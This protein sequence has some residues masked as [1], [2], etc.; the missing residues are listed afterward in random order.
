MNVIK[1]LEE[2]YISN[3]EGDWEH[4]WNVKI[5]SIDMLGWL[6]S[7]NLVDTGVDGKAFPVYKVERSVDDWVH[8]KVENSI[9]NGSGGTGNLEEILIVFITWL[10]KVDSNFKK[11]K[12]LNTVAQKNK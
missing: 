7:I 4:D 8:C 11:K 10:V 1:L 9:F 6:V 2:W 3:C 12:R 5:Q